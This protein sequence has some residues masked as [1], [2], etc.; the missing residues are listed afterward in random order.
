MLASALPNLFTLL[1][2]CA[3]SSL[4]LYHEMMLPGLAVSSLLS[5]RGLATMPGL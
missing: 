5:P 1:Y 3:H 4:A 2:L